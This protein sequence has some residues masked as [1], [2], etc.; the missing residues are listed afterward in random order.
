MKIGSAIVGASAAAL[1]MFSLTGCVTTESQGSGTGAGARHRGIVKHEHKGK[2]T[3][4]AMTKSEWETEYGQVEDD[5]SGLY[6]D[7]LMGSSDMG[8]TVEPMPPAQDYGTT[9]IYIVQKGDVLSQIAVDFDTTTATL[10]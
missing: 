5:N 9:E 8:N 1:C 4:A 7:E 2:E 6:G 3:P 10:I